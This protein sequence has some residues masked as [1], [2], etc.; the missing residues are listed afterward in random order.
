[1]VLSTTSVRP[2]CNGIDGGLLGSKLRGTS[3]GR[4][5]SGWKTGKVPAD[6]TITL[7]QRFTRAIFK[8]V[9]HRIKLNQTVDPGVDVPHRGAHHAR[10]CS[11]RFIYYVFHRIRRIT[12][13][14]IL[15]NAR[16]S[17]KIFDFGPIHTLNTYAVSRRRLRNGY[18]H[19]RARLYLDANNVWNNMVIS[20]KLV[21]RPIHVYVTRR[22][23]AQ[24][25]GTR[26]ILSPFKTFTTTL[27]YL[28][29]KEIIIFS[30][31]L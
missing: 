16:A 2:L 23:R 1:M 25:N 6:N 20:R 14:I 31:A 7:G 10:F 12:N 9:K 17:G 8:R 28:T 4:F 27:L 13:T 11:V 3:S 5:G 22:Y 18:A 29:C 15:E 19:R 30:K 21:C 24:H 26:T